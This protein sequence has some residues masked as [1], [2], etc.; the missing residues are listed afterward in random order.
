MT[1]SA[2]ADLRELQRKGQE[3]RKE[4]HIEE[5][6][7][8]Y[9]VIWE[10]HRSDANEWDGW[11]FA[12]CL[13]RMGHYERSLAICREVEQ[14][15]PEFDPIH[16]V[17]AWCLYYLYIKKEPEEI[18]DNPQ[19]F[20]RAADE[21]VRLAE[22]QWSSRMSPYILTCFRMTKYL[23]PRTT[24]NAA[25]QVLEWTDR[26]DPSKLEAKANYSTGSDGKQKRTLSDRE[27]YYNTRAKALQS[28][29]RHEEALCLC[30]EALSAFPE[31]HPDFEIWMRYRKGMC[32]AE[33]G[34]HD[35]AIEILRSALRRK[36]VWFIRHALAKAYAGNK[37]LDS[38]LRYGVEAV[39]IDNR[40][41]MGKRWEILL[42]IAQV[43]MACNENDM[44]KK[45]AA[46]A[47]GER[48]RMGWGA[49]TKLDSVCRGLGVTDGDIDSSHD[50]KPELEKYWQSVRLSLSPRGTGTVAN[51]LPSRAGFIKGDDGNSYYFSRNAFRA[52]KHRLQPGVRVAYFI[53]ESYD[54]RKG[55]DSME[56]VDMELLDS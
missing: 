4:G 44:A 49:N 36:T 15:W 21:I 33:L 40:N 53:E 26:L 28:L 17:H 9:R 31:V 12:F 24:I 50:L 52:S 8:F 38:A 46:Y 20:L 42:T 32:L 22:G 35:E 6:L 29:A 18:A 56:A 13:R 14:E 16:N 11:G 10:E 23:S 37:D 3:L 48:R 51:L 55:C 34:R 19:E 7:P 1:E 39:A 25:Q 5:A 30:D 41:E 47:A 45:H 54:A 2:Q 27:R 43:L